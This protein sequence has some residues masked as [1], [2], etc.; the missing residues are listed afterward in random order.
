[1]FLR[2]PTCTQCPQSGVEWMD[3]NMGEG[4]RAA[5]ETLLASS[6][7][8]E[9]QDA[10]EQSGMAPPQEMLILEK[11]SLHPKNKGMLKF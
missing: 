6:R 2:A 7:L 5:G 8:Q 1:M 4:V 10:S 9:Q 3:V 11:A